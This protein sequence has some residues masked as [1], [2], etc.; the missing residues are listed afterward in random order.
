MEIELGDT[1]SSGNSIVDDNMTL[2]DE[3]DCDED[4]IE[5][6]EDSLFVIMHGLISRAARRASY[7]LIGTTS[8]DDDDEDVLHNPRPSVDL[9][10]PFPMRRVVSNDSPRA[11]KRSSYLRNS[12][13][14]LWLPTRNDDDNSDDTPNKDKSSSPPLGEPIQFRRSYSEGIALSSLSSSSRSLRLSLP[15]T[16]RR[17]L[18]RRSGVFRGNTSQAA[19][20][21]PSESSIDEG[22]LEWLELPPTAAA[23]PFT[24]LSSEPRRSSIS[25]CLDDIGDMELG[26]LPGRPLEVLEVANES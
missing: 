26:H 15:P 5:E 19:F 13:R 25:G 18:S 12:F 24:I 10:L 3:D 17:R 2:G 9:S 22:D 8:S 20:D 11:R 1:D 16:I 7:S 14:S 21:D 6:G 23:S 4:D